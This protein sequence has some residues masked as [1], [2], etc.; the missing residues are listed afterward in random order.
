MVSA[1][2]DT[3]PG[4]LIMGLA[5][6]STPAG[7]AV[8][9][10]ALAAIQEAYPD[11]DAW[12][13]CLVEEKVPYVT[14]LVKETLRF[15]TVIPICLPRTSIKDIPY[16]DTVIPAGT[17]FFMVMLKISETQNPEKPLTRATERL[18]GGLR[19]RPLQDGG[20][21]HRRALPQRPRG[22][23]AALRLRRRLAHVRRLASRQPRALHRLHPH[24]HRLPARAGRRRGRPPGHALPRLQRHAHVADPRP[25]A[26]QDEA[27]AQRRGAAAPVD[28]RGRRPHQGPLTRR[29]KDGT[30]AHL[31]LQKLQD[32]AVCLSPLHQGSSSI[33]AVT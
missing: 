28:R 22:R 31:V 7:Q 16:Q 29:I 6:L 30:A 18:R 33:D 32:L 4:T 27:Q 13:K 2:L 10:K 23:H 17:T 26:L 25:Q 14:A 8:Q 3:V 24:H 19:R 15:F 12:E 1:G 11:G 20:Q 9:A 21:V 5:H